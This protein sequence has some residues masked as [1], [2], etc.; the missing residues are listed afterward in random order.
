MFLSSNRGVEQ[1]I[2][3]FLITLRVAN[4]RALTIKAIVSGN[5]SSI[6]FGIRGASSGGSETLVD[7]QP[8]NVIEIGGGTCEKPDVG[9]EASTN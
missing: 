4:Q 1:V 5:P 9:V 6:R 2:A 3:P 8:T 7:G